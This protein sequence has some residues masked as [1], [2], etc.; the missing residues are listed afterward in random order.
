MKSR[1][2]AGLA[3]FAVLAA[4]AWYVLS[5]FQAFAD[6]AEA[7]RTGDRGR[8]E[9]LV[10]FPAVRDGLKTQLNTRLSTALS[11]DRALSDGPFGAL[12]ALLGPTVV[13]QVVDAAVTPDGVAAIIRSGRAPLSDVTGGKTALPPP[14]DTA[15][16]PPPGA[17]PARA[18]PPGA[19]FAYADLNH[20]RAT[21]VSSDSAHAPLT[22]VLERRGLGWKLVRIELPPA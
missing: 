16:P 18:K 10:D 8:L 9:A 3:V 5:P 22:W 12:G 21:T 14:P 4:V 1:F 13:D 15:P 19:R 6:L 20:V 11:S 7:G 2:W 17:P